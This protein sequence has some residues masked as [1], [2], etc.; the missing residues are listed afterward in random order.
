MP[1]PRQLYILTQLRKRAKI[2]LAE[3]ARACGLAGG[4]AYESAS[5]WESGKSIPHRQLRSGFLSYLAHTLELHTD[6]VLLTST[7]DVL[8]RAWGW[9]PLD[10]TDWQIVHRADVLP[11]REVGGGDAVRA[12]ALAL[13]GQ[14]TQHGPLPPLAPLPPG[15]RIPYTPNPLFVG[16][17]GEICILAEILQARSPNA[18]SPVPLAAVVGAGGMGKTQMAVEFVHRFGRCFGGGIFWLSFANSAAIPAAVAACGGAEGMGLRP[19]FDRLSLASQVEL[20]RTAWE[21]ATPRLLVF[22]NCEQPDLV[23]RWCPQRGGCRVLITSRRVYWDAGIGVS[24]LPLGLLSRAESVAL[25]RNHCP[26]QQ[27]GDQLLTAIAAELDDLPLALHLGGNYLA[28]AADRLSPSD[29]LHELRQTQGAAT[30][31]LL[32]HQSLQGLGPG[33]RAMRSPTDHTGNLEQIIALSYGQLDRRDPLDQQAHALLGRA[34]VLAP[35]EPIPIDILIATAPAAGERPGVTLA[36]RRL[37]DLGLVEENVARSGWNVRMHRLIHA[38]LQ[39][40]ADDH[41]AHLAVAQALLNAAVI[42]NASGNQAG[43]LDLQVHLRVLTD[44][45][46]AHGDAVAADLSY[47]LSRHLGEIEQYAEATQYNQRSLAVREHCF[48]PDDR[49]VTENLHY[50]GELLDWQGD[51]A[52]A[53]PYHIR[54]LDIRRRALGEDHPDTATSLNHVGEILHA[55]CDYP[56]ARGHYQQALAAFMR[57]VGPDHPA[58]A[59]VENNLGLLLNAMG[60]YAQ[61]QPHAE[62]A[63]AIWEQSATPHGLRQS[64]ALNNLGY[65]LRAQGRYREARPILERALAIREA[66]YGPANTTVGVTLNH[67]GRSAYYLGDLDAAQGSLERAIT[68]FT[69]S[70][71]DDH[72]ITASTIGNLGMVHLERGDLA[73][74]QTRLEY[75]QDIH[76]RRCGTDHRHT[77]RSA[78]RLGIFFAQANDAERARTFFEQALTIRERVLGPSHHDTANTCIHLGT[79]L[80]ESGAVSVARPYIERGL[81]AHLQQLGTA[82]H[83]T[84]RS[85]LAV[86]CLREALGDAEAATTHFR[87][88]LTIYRH[89]LGEHHSFTAKAQARGEP[90]A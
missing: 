76:Q 90:Q 49:R 33:G 73:Q 20:V 88:A 62:R 3:M 40:R 13:V 68:I 44:R 47:Q 36:L 23:R 17:A 5:A 29:Y 7:W 9:D 8:V 14:L 65:L 87:Q 63:V 46:L 37:V 67:L 77:G 43:F 64:M 10:A 6:D 27:G 16:R 30:G 52:A 58:V 57:H 28:R 22:D 34:A 71:G 48:G 45:A 75:A 89:T 81:A 12:P 86:G 39:N 31:S 80:L 54:A 32:A 70:L 74:A 59:D 19:D 66:A 21:A 38:F 56:N 24:I 25:L 50:L 1:D 51:Y 72:P 78:N 82:H 35:G 4:R 18:I 41:D 15:S 83:Y 42:L 11:S 26:S 61:A 2:S 85:L 60:A 84:A 55:L 79:L 69:Q 53:R